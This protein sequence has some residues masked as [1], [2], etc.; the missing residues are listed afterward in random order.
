MPTRREGSVR[1]RWELAD[2]SPAAQLDEVKPLSRRARSVLARRIGD[3]FVQENFVR[4]FG[5]LRML[6]GLDYHNA[7]FLGI[8]CEFTRDDFSSE[9]LINHELVAY[10]N[11]LG[12]FHYFATSQFVAKALNRRP[13]LAFIGTLLLFRHK[14]AAHRSIDKPRKE[15]SDQ[16]AL[17]LAIHT[18][19]T[20][21]LMIPR[22]Q[23]DPYRPMGR[24]AYVRSEQWRKMFAGFKVRLDSGRWCRFYPERDH[25]MVM[26]EAYGLFSAVIRAA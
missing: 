16:L 10:L 1:D 21:V 17:S 2:P 9:H 5:A 8:V 22:K 13:S 12:Q 7:N 3:D 4:L 14:F 20:P 23:A 11:R 25:P 18:L 6:E 24:K 19:D 26:K 15:D